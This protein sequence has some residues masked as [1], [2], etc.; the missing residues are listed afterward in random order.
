M[1]TVHIAVQRRLQNT[2]KHGSG[3]ITDVEEGK[4]DGQFGWFVPVKDQ[5]NHAWPEAG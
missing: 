5:G 4:T 1:D 2:E 3:D